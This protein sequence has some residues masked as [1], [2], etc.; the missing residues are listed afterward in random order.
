VASLTVVAGITFWLGM[1]L[2]LAIGFLADTD[3]IADINH[4]AG[5][6]NQAIGLAV[7]GVLIA[8][9]VMVTLI[10]RRGRAVFLNFRLPGPILTLGQTLLGVI[11][12]GAA[13]GGFTP[14]APTPCSENHDRAHPF[15][16]PAWATRKSSGAK[17]RVWTTSP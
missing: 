16:H 9:L 11:D 5:W 1:G 3:S 15:S 13:A 7:F 6:A 4:L 17:R 2:V 10:R 8:Y 14:R 12:V